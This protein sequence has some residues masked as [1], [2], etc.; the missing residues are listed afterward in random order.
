MTEVRV[1]CVCTAIQLSD[2]GEKLFR[3]DVL[4]LAKD[5]AERSKDLALAKQNGAVACKDVVRCQEQRP[6][7]A[8]QQSPY[9]LVQNG[10]VRETKKPDPIPTQVAQTVPQAAP[11]QKPQ[12]FINQDE[13]VRQIAERVAQALNK[14][15]VV[16]PPSVHQETRVEDTTP[17]FI[18]NDLVKPGVAEVEI[19]STE[20]EGGGVDAAASALKKR[21]GKKDE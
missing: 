6:A 20:S 14:T 12:P 17:R 9:R 1:Q 18:P 4:F 13:M 8:P 15:V 10:P 21:R 7:T 3:G 11:V 5:R 16:M 19:K 2:L